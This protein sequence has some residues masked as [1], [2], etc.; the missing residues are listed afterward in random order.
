[1]VAKIIDIDTTVHPYRTVQPTRYTLT[2]DD[3]A[4]VSVG[5]DL[6]E[7]LGGDKFDV[8]NGLDAIVMLDGET[9]DAERAAEVGRIV[10][11]NKLVADL[12]EEPAVIPVEINGA[13][14]F[15]ITVTV[16][17]VFGGTFTLETP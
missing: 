6:Q 13:P 7:V 8:T 17:T 11:A 5:L 14:G 12:A 9:S 2:D 3:T 1:M 4:R 10:L 16:N 15:R